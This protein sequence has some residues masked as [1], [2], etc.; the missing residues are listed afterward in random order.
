M[1]RTDALSPDHDPSDED[2]MRALAAGR[3]EAIGPLHER[4]A[5]RVFHLVAQTLDA[6]AAEE[7]VQEVFVAVWRKAGTFDPARGTFRAW[8]M[9]IAHLRVANEL[10]RRSRRPRVAA[11]QNGSALA[12]V[13]D[14]GD[15]PLENALRDDRRSALRAA[16]ESLPGAQRRALSLAFFEERTH[17]EVANSLNLPLGTAKTR[18]RAGIHRLRVLL[19]PLVAILLAAV[20]VLEMRRGTQRLELLRQDRALRLVTASDLVPIRLTAAPGVSP[21]THGRYLSRPG[22][23]M[24]V[25]TLSK[26][27]SPPAGQTYQVWLLRAGQWVSLGTALPDHSGKALMITE[28]PYLAAPPEALRVTIEPAAGSASPTGKDLIV[29]PGG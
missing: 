23:E 7:I 28:G 26:F 9:R 3:P 16:L 29:W 8:V 21:E 19:A 6:H 11:G 15:D 12:F 4:Y 20:G 5:R 1:K 13:P 2:L 10:R 27:P 17:E 25:V 14:R 18:I 22:A 24:A